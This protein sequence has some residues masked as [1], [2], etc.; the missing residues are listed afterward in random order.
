MAIVLL[1][2]SVST[3][4]A[5]DFYYNTETTK[6][7][8]ET[9]TKCMH[10]DLVF[11]TGMDEALKNSDLM[12][13]GIYYVN[14]TYTMRMSNN[15]YGQ[16]METRPLYCDLR[17]DKVKTQEKAYKEARRKEAHALKIKQQAEKAKIKAL[18]EERYRKKA[19]EKAKADKVRAIAKAKALA[20]K[21]EKDRKKA[22]EKAKA[23]KVRAIA[24]AKAL[25]IKA[26][27]DRKKAIEK[28]KTDKVRAIAEAKKKVL[29]ASEIKKH[30]DNVI[31]V[32]KSCLKSKGR[33]SAFTEVVIVQ[34]VI[35]IRGIK[36][37]RS[38]GSFAKCKLS[39]SHSG[40]FI[41]KLNGRFELTNI[42]GKQIY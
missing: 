20:I 1:V 42:H 10:K 21:A 28:E 26:E 4:Q 2:L 3:T 9:V 16:W 5:G 39:K 23:D 36:A 17:S 12:L 34:K 33:N 40:T 38:F 15:Q 8:K 30:V 6:S 41:K 13:L 19:I 25:A 35:T 29:R 37:T 22:I 7:Q 14:G 27:K 32:A 24:K 11:V 31:A 18:K